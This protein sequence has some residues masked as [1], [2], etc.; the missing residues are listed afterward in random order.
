M[1]QR[2]L[3]LLL[4]ALL[5]ALLP[6]NARADDA[7]LL[8]RIVAVVND[9]IILLSELRQKQQQQVREVDAEQLLQSMVMD[10]IQLQLA[11]RFNI[12]VGNEEVNSVLQ[13]QALRLDMSLVDYVAALDE[14][15]ID[16]A[17]V[18]G[19]IRQ[20]L[21][22]QKLRGQLL[23]RSIRVRDEEIQTF[24]TT[25]AASEAF[26][27]EYKIG[28]IGAE[29]EDL[30]Q[31]IYQ[32]LQEQ[33]FTA[34]AEQWADDER[35][36]VRALD[37]Q[38]ANKLPVLFV[39]LAPGLE[40]GATHAPVKNSRGW[41]IVSLLDKRL[42]RSN[43]TEYQVSII[44]LYSNPVRDAAQTAELAR[45]LHQRIA[46]DSL[47]F[48]EAA[49]DYSDDQL[50]ASA[51]GDL[52]WLA[53][54][55]DSMPAELWQSLRQAEADTLLLLDAGEAGWHLAQLQQ[56]RVSD[57]SLERAT[58]SARQ[59]IF[60]NKMRQAL[61]KWLAEIRAQAYVELRDL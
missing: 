50:S 54:R 8:D 58:E 25:R 53:A 56:S 57:N 5:C 21:L 19:Q 48:A 47:D 45:N 42:A 4:S 33:N 3:P 2:V 7:E 46:A 38:P 24:F 26:G 52:G 36:R 6:I 1:N 10:A 41:N 18:R 55:P 30:A 28:Y 37:W 43:I 12:S 40:I 16:I 20:Q 60:E 39:E 13:N 35:L 31:Q 17:S 11:N 14:Q 27:I 34:V 22:V 51:G 59:L 23:G 61:P 9:E 15:N 29:D 49:R 44:S 32:Q